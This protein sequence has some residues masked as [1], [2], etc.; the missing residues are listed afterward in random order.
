M[1]AAALVRRKCD[2]L[3]A[4]RSAAQHPI[5]RRNTSLAKEKCSFSGSARVGQVSVADPHVEML[6]RESGA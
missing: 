3:V 6:M 2:E 1:V 5:S 4:L